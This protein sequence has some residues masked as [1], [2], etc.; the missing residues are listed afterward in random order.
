M[1]ATL[2]AWSPGVVEACS[3]ADFSAAMG[4]LTSRETVSFQRV[5]EIAAAVLVATGGVSHKAVAYGKLRP[6]LRSTAIKR[7]GD[8]R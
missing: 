6:G 2:K 4:D 8:P 7:R 3:R 5:C 1:K